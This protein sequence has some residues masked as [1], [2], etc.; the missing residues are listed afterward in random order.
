MTLLT[1]VASITAMIL[2]TLGLMGL[3]TRSICAS[4][5]W[6]KEIQQVAESLKDRPLQQPKFPSCRGPHIDWRFKGKLHAS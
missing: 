2:T 5:L 4:K 6:Q 3:S 1:A